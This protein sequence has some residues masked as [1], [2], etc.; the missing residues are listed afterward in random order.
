LAVDDR[1]GRYCHEQGRGQDGHDCQHFKKAPR[2]ID[3]A[4]A[5]IMGFDRAK[6]LVGK[7]IKFW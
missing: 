5:S 2:R 3:L 7:T 4:M 1:T 6:E